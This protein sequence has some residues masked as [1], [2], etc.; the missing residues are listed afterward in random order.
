MY[1]PAEEKHPEQ[2]TFSMALY[3]IT[4]FCGLSQ[5]FMSTLLLGLI[6]LVLCFFMT[7]AQRATAQNTIYAS[8]VEWTR[9]TLSVGTFWLCP[10]A[11][12]FACYFVWKSVDFIEMRRQL[13]ATNGDLG[14]T[15][16]LMKAYVTNNVAKVERIADYCMAPVI[17]WWL[18]RCLHGFLK[19]K[20]SEP[21]FYP[22]GLL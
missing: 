2:R 6:L 18:R 10:I 15:I 11:L 19:A 20:R 21:I 14:D 7:K 1:A 16:N 13:D 5:F 8:H 17:F 4:A 3:I 9:R 12:G 22:E